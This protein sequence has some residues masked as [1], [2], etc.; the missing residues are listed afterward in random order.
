MHMRRVVLLVLAFL[1]TACAAPAGATGAATHPPA[2]PAP[3]AAVCLAS[4]PC[5]GGAAGL[6]TAQVWVEPDARALPALH[7]IEGANTAIWL[8]V[9]ILTD[10]SVIHALEDAA[11]RGVVVRVLL[12]TNPYGGGATDAQKTLAELNAAGVRARAAGPAYTYTHAKTMVVD[13]AT[14]YVMTCNLSLSGLGGSSAATNREYGV[15]DTDPADVAALSAILQADWDQTAP[16]PL[17]DPHLV[18]SPINARATL[19]GLIGA[20]RSSLEVEDEEMADAASEDA[21]IAAAG[22]GVRVEV[23]LPAP[24][25]GAPPAP[26]VARLVRGGVQVHWSVVLYMHAKLI[27]ADHTLAFTGS[28]NFSATSLDANREIGLLIAAPTAVATLD[29]TFA[30]DWQQGEPYATA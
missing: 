27:V 13:G 9:Y 4:A 14:A 25:A 11:T 19:L 10:S 30:T 17:T 1:T 24:S 18:I 15:V 28:E 7:A 29:S 8:E 22:R 16:P 12:E 20:A 3:T 2:T 21:L 5:Q 23:V 26:D 6:P